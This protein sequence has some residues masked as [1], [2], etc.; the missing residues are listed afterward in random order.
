MAQEPAPFY[1][2]CLYEQRWLK[3]GP[4]QPLVEST[5]SYTLHP[6]CKGACCTV[7]DV[8]LPSRCWNSK[9]FKLEP[10]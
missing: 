7:C 10:Q 9:Q 5:F 6:L 1:Q 2:C 8:S 4:S 3:T